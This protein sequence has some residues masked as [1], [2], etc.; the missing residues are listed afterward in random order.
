MK[1]PNILMEKYECFGDY[2][3]SF[4]CFLESRYAIDINQIHRDHELHSIKVDHMSG[5][6]LYYRT[7]DNCYFHYRFIKDDDQSFNIYIED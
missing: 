6:I 5:W 4:K 7:F 2:I 1:V 3:K